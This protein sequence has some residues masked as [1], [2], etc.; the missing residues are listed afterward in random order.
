MAIQNTS[1]FPSQVNLHDPNTRRINNSRKIL[2]VAIMVAAILL[3][4]A[5]VFSAFNQHKAV[6]GTENMGAQDTRTDQSPNSSPVQ[7]K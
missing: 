6:R 3:I 7:K 4:G 1:P 5:L 2:Y